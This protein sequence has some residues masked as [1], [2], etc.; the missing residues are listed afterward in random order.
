MLLEVSGHELEVTAGTPSRR[1]TTPPS[2][3]IR[4]SGEITV[5]LAVS[6]TLELV[7]GELAAVVCRFNG[8]PVATDPRIRGDTVDAGDL[9]KRVPPIEQLRH[10]VVG[11][12]QPG[13]PLVDETRWFGVESVLG[14]D[15]QRFGIG[16]LCQCGAGA[17]VDLADEPV[18]DDLRGLVRVDSVVSVVAIDQ[19]VDTEWL[20]VYEYLKVG[21]V[22][23]QLAVAFD[24]E[25]DSAVAVFG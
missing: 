7:V 9:A 14:V 3:A 2:P 5:A 22:A 19:V 20:V 21:D 24:R 10:H 17:V 4:W 16:P 15:A 23:E 18:M 6:Q 8:I 13:S 12:D 25:R 1:P 11:R